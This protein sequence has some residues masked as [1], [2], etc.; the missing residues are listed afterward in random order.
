MLAVAVNDSFAY[1]MGRTFGKTS[2]ITLS[3]NKTVEGLLGRAVWTV[4]FTLIMM[5][6]LGK[7]PWLFCEVQSFDLRP[8]NGVDC[9][10]YESPVY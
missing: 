6:T 8:F 5:N 9:A 2:L 4:V 7:Y 3:P 1:V 10:V